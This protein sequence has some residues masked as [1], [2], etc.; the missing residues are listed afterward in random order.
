VGLD[1]IIKKLKETKWEEESKATIVGMRGTIAIVKQTTPGN[2]VTPILREILR[3]QLVG[4]G[5][6][7]KDDLAIR[8]FNHYLDKRGADFALTI[9]DIKNMNSP[10]IPVPGPIDI[11]KNSWQ[12]PG[13]RVEWSKQVALAASAKT[14][15]NYSGSVLW[16]WD[17][18]AI[19]N[20]TVKYTGKVSVS[21][22]GVVEWLGQ[23][24]FFDRFD[25]DPRWNWSPST[26]GGR[27]R[28]G[29][30]RTRIGYMLNLGTDFDIIGPTAEA[31]QSSSAKHLVFS[32]KIIAPAAVKPAGNI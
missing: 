3:E 19:A 6:H 5:G 4:A 24:I 31:S 26:P 30:R 9:V 23:V 10:A 17:N 14:P 15:Q 1:D 27:S 28:R 11:R 2:I 13:V 7:A 18:G 8:L 22:A 32:G 16:A 29:E 12:D 20:Y 25:L 21:K